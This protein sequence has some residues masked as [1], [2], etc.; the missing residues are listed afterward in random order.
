MSNFRE[1]CTKIENEISSM[2]TDNEKI[3]PISDGIINIDSYLSAKYKILWIL[4]GTTLLHFLVLPLSNGPLMIRYLTLLTPMFF[5]AAFYAVQN[6]SHRHPVGYA[7][8]L[9]LT[10]FLAINEIKRP[11]G[12]VEWSKDIGRLSMAVHTELDSPDT[13]L[14]TYFYETAVYRKRLNAHGCFTEECMMAPRKTNPIQSANYFYDLENKKNPGIYKA[15]LYLGSESP[16]VEISNSTFLFSHDEIKNKILTALHLEKSVQDT[17]VAISNPVE[18]QKP[19]IP[20]PTHPILGQ[21]IQGLNEWQ[22]LFFGPRVTLFSR[23][24]SG[25][26]EISGSFGVNDL[27]TNIKNSKKYTLV[28][29]IDSIRWKN[30]NMTDFLP[31]VFKTYVFEM[32][33]LP[34]QWLNNRRIEKLFYVPEK[35]IEATV[36]TTR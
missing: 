28:L 18:W 31:I 9:G 20:L 1:E 17:K 6:I 15:P 12:P 19:N 21:S 25:E 30:H 3:L 26:L 16:A 22:P 2:K 27:T 11:D 32:G 10:G 36:L 13:T 5:V 24:W 35:G 34:I 4:V 14:F 29:Q 23:L 33:T 8:M 7:I